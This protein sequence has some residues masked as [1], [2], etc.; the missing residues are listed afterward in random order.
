MDAF[1]SGKLNG[2]DN[3]NSL[4]ISID[5]SNGV[6]IGKSRNCCKECSTNFSVSSVP[7]SVKK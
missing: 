4:L 5:G 1:L 7:F 6:N 2:K 3:D